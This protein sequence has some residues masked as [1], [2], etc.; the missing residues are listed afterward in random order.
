MT[1]SESPQGELDDVLV[2]NSNVS[3]HLKAMGVN[4]DYDKLSSSGRLIYEMLGLLSNPHMCRPADWR[5][6]QNL[7]CMNITAFAS[8]TIIGH[9]YTHSDNL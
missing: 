1:T 5:A 3:K 7:L 2:G 8:T 9:T 4:I 6:S